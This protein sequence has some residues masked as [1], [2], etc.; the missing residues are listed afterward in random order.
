MEFV[1]TRHKISPV[2]PSNQ[3]KNYRPSALNKVCIIFEGSIS[4]N[5][6]D[7]RK[8]HAI[9]L[10]ASQNMFHIIHNHG[11]YKDLIMVGKT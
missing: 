9:G 5:T 1:A 7:S 11:K 2:S 6:D 3:V 8:E 10:V 4:R